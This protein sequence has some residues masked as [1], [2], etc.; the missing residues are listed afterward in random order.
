MSVLRKSDGEKATAA[1]PGKIAPDSGKVSPGYRAARAFWTSFCGSYLKANYAGLENVPASGACILLANHASF[2]D[3]GLIG[4]RIER[5]LH[6][7]ARASLMRAPGFGALLRA[8]NTHAIR[9]EGI[10]R[11]AIRACAQILRGGWGLVV[12][13]EGTRSRDGRV[14]KP[15]GGVGMILEE[16]PETPCV[17]IILKGTFDA[18]GP[19]K[20]LPRPKPVSMSVGAPFQIEPR[21]EGEKRRGYFG[22][23]AERIESAWRDLGAYE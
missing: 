16:A 21:G 8:L 7:L 19:G 13:P 4:S 9:R 18:M 11:E 3:P 2:L 23:C 20:L 22:R 15:L 1:P 6:Y 14:G 10:D 12:F 5:E 17:P